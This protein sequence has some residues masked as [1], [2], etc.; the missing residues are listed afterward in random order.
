MLFPDMSRTAAVIV[1]LQKENYSE[2][3]CPVAGYK[4]VLANA[5]NVISACRQAGIMPIYTQHLLDSMGRDGR[6][7]EPRDHSGTPRGSVAGTSGSEICDEVAPSE[8]DII[9]T[10]QRF[11]AFYNTR[12]ESILRRF[13]IRNLI[14]FGV[15]TEHCL[16]TTV[17]DASMR[18]YRIALVAD[19][20]GG[21]TEISHKAAILN[22]ANW[23]FGGTILSSDQIVRAL[24]GQEFRAWRYPGSN[25]FPYT[26]ETLET[27]Y[28][29]L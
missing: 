6:A 16:E 25:Q 7:Y 29:S 18:D 11:S 17:Y 24:G 14:I 4:K 15:W 22:M 12:L 5:A 21:S 3:Q 1:D 8:D 28:G 19:S 23:L 10:K 26:L 9:V 27:M 20:C 13:D 2:G